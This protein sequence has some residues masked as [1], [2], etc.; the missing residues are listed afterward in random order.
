MPAPMCFW[1]FLVLFRVPACSSKRAH[2]PLT[3]DG[4]VSRR[5]HTSAPRQR[6]L[7]GDARVQR[8][9][10]CQHM[11]E[12]RHM[13]MYVC[14]CAFLYTF[15]HSCM[16]L[17]SLCAHKRMGCSP[18]HEQS[19]RVCVCMCLCTC[20]RRACTCMYIPMSS[21]PPGLGLVHIFR[22]FDR[23][24]LGAIL[25]GSRHRPRTGCCQKGR[26]RCHAMEQRACRLAPTAPLGC[27]R[28]RH[29]AGG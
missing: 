8:I 26:F 25:S 12:Y 17:Y 22:E 1:S 10:I 13:C 14:M 7:L 18:A 15:M 6:Q 27:T 19:F 11:F 9:C 28:G 20:K 21:P 3:V 23:G 24:P 2:T 5:V 29:C 4:H 16:Y